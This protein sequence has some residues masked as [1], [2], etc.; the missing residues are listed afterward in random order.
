M[1]L[2]AA[3]V[4]SLGAAPL[5][6]A[7]GGEAPAARVSTQAGGKVLVAELP[8]PV[9]SA[10][11]AGQGEGKGGVFLLVRPQGEVDGERS[12]YFLDPRGKGRL[13]LV[14]SGLPGGAKALDV[15]ELQGSG[16]PELVLGTLGQLFSLGPLNAIAAAGPL[17]QRID[18]PGFDLR[19]LSP[20]PLRVAG[21]G[22]ELA[23]A[24]PGFLRLY[25]PDGRGGVSV[26]ARLAL[27]LSA[28]REPTG[29][30]VTSPPVHRLAGA[31]G[32]PD[33]YASG[34]LR[35]GNRRVSSVLLDTATG[36]H[37]EAWGRLPGAEKVEQSWYLRVDGRPCLIVTSQTADELNLLEKKRL[38]V[39]PLAADR[40]RAG[41]LPLA[42]LETSITRWF[43]MSA[44]V[45]DLD[46]DGRQDLL[47]AGPDGLQGD[48]LGV[49]VHPGLGGGRFGVQ[50]RKVE[51]KQTPERW[52]LVGDLSGD[53]AADLVAVHEGALEVW[54]TSP[55]GRPLARQPSF[56]FE[57]PAAGKAERSV[58]VGAGEE[59]AETRRDQ[60]GGWDDLTAVDLDGDDQLEILLLAVD[61]AGRGRLVI[62]R[63]KP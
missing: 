27:P 39:F 60:R 3:L 47:L 57:L 22:R 38:R 29:L 44:D 62:A 56:R 36:E 33:L 63:P 21:S 14:R 17:A 5:L 2:L 53:G 8:G 10:L 55:K 26:A 52:K 49:F 59:G 35:H 54:P 11:V 43:D 51:I 9:V 30:A 58:S 48:N 50:A 18:H 13:S 25:R 37:L 12:L 34:P 23:V 32:Q 20:S 1:R 19:S 16:Q 4:L 46:G 40:T 41:K 28:R 31:E 6:L 7:E 42:Q 61:L 24:E 15:L 45:A